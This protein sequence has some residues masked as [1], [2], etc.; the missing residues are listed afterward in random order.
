MALCAVILFLG[1]LSIGK[2]FTLLLEPLR[3]EFGIGPGAQPMAFIAVFGL[4]AW[5]FVLLTGYFVD[6]VG[7]RKVMLVG[8]AL[9]L[10]VLFY[11]VFTEIEL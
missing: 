5:I 11:F 4:T 1:G 6:R 3:D 7:P 10:D 8:V 2:S 9:I